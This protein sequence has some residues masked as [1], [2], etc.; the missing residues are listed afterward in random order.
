MKT[1]SKADPTRPARTLIAGGDPDEVIV[2]PKDEDF[3]GDDWMEAPEV[4]A[5]ATALIDGRECF[6]AAGLGVATIVYLWKRKASSEPRRI[7]GKCQRPSGLLKR[8][9]GADFIIWL[10]ANNCK[11]FTRW[12][13]EALVFHEL[14]HASMAD[15][16]PSLIPHD[17]EGFGQEIE[18]Y[19]LWKPDIERIAASVK[20]AQQSLPFDAPPNCVDC[21]NGIA[22]V[23]HS[24]VHVSGQRCTAGR[25]Q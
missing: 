22:L 4:G 17:F 19:G 23:E 24:D 15:D 14:S 6:G 3:A 25:V 7:L 1:K 5:I 12:Q 9:A 10:A 8:F 11:G 18:R 20:V 13:L 21:N 16:T 2:T